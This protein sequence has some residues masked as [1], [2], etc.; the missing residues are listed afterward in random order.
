MVIEE[1]ARLEILLPN[2]ENWWHI[3][4]NDIIQNSLSISE[5]CMEDSGFTLGGVN[6]GQLT[7]KFRL[8]G[9]NSFNIIGSKINVFSW[10][11][12]EETAINNKSVRFRG[13]FWVTSATKTSDIYNISASDA[14][15]WLD[16]VNYNDGGD[17]SNPIYRELS[18]YRVDLSDCFKIVVEQ[19]NKVL[20]RIVKLNYIDNDNIINNNHYSTG[21]CLLPPDIVGEISTKNP[22]DY[23]SWIAELACGFAY[24]CYKQDGFHEPYVQGGD[25]EAYIKIGQ[26]NDEDVV[27][28]KYDEVELNTLEIAD[29]V[30]NFSR[31]Y[32]KFYDGYDY[33]RYNSNGGITIDISENPFKDGWYGYLEHENHSEDC[34][35]YQAIANVM[36]GKIL[37]ISHYFRPF[38]LKYHGRSHFGLG[39]KI[40][41]P[42]GRF[43]VVTAIK[44]QF[45][46]GTNLACAGKDSR[47]LS[48]AAKRSQAAKVKD[49]AYTKINTEKSKIL[50]QLE[51]NKNDLQ[52]Q[53]NNKSNDIS[54]IDSKIQELEDKNFQQQIWDIWDAINGGGE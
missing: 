31:V 50:K 7:A 18:S 22:R 41:L 35:C 44:W 21:Y 49:L 51:S 20:D 30:L 6:S 48:V 38:K 24:A 32:C 14:M 16:S 29:F 52:E 27:E 10:F 33:S 25:H 5:K 1:H 2:E 37:E 15:I 11:G 54:N 39:Q 42:D 47:L 36:Y 34:G 9:T 17:D 28:I 13:V 40:K 3:G 23:V 19:T 46:G 8:Q 4:E 53:I 12:D 43:S 26:F 45:R